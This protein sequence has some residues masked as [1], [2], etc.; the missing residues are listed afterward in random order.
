MI[1]YPSIDPIALE[2]GPLKVHWYGLMYLVGFAGGYWL[3]N[4]RAKKSGQWTSE[5]ISDLVF[6]GAMGVILGGRIGYVLFYNFSHFLTDPLSLFCLLYTSPS[7]RD[8]G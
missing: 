6:W 3:L 5:Q 7:P 4:Y 1:A 8:R 2:L